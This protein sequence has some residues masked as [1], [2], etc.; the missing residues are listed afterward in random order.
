MRSLTCVVLLF[1]VF[2]LVAVSAAQQASPSAAPKQIIATQYAP[3]VL[4]NS[5][6]VRALVSGELARLV[7]RTLSVRQPSSDAWRHPAV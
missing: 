5:R 3:V 1:T 6:F 7:P 2:S 4:V